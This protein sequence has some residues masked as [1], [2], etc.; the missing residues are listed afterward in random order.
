MR[1]LHLNLVHAQEARRIL[2]RLVGFTASPFLMSVFGSTLS[3]GRV[4]SVVARMVIERECDIDKFIPEDF[5]NLHVAIFDSNKNKINTKYSE[6]IIKQE[7]AENLYDKIKDIENYIVLD[8]STEDEKKYPPPP[9]VTSSLQ[10]IMAKNHG[11]NAERTMKA[12]QSL[13]ESG[14]C[15]YIRTD[16]VRASDE[17][18]SDLRD[19]LKDKKLNFPI[20]IN[21]F[22]NKDSAQ[23]AHECIRPSDLYL[24]PYD[25][26]AIIDPDEKLVYENIWKYFVSSQMSPAVFQSVKYT[27]SP[28]NEP[29][30][31]F[32][33]TGKCLKEKGYLE[34]LGSNFDEK[35]DLPSLKIGDKLKANIK[36]IKVEKK[37]TQPPARYSED[38][39]I[40]ELVNKNIGRPATY[41]DLLSKIIL[42][43]YVEKKGNVYHATDLGKKI[44]SI[45]IKYFSFMNYDYTSKMEEQLD[46]IEA[47]KYNYIEMLKKFYSE[48]KKEI[49]S[50]YIDNGGTLCEKCASPMIIK[51]TKDLQKK[52]LA[53]S[54]WPKCNYTLDIK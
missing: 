3:A 31:L 25:N 8:S 35:I 36:N 21:T 19:F 54:A 32:K 46:K 7:D 13:Y 6:K 48:Y 15:T 39:L 24:N 33:V 5:W 29:G 43:N 53:C 40:K 47:G 49:D 12:A 45:L 10:Q 17:S 18:I 44:N 16:S 38:R 4:Q 28:E 23:D 2:D 30:L 26:Y 37:Q 27:F 34:I 1:E 14:Y 51:N 52:F 41:A 50:A 20:K 11:F 42:R 22:K 9:L